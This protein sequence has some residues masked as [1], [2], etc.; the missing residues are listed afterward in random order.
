MVNYVL[1]TMHGERGVVMEENEDEEDDNNIPDWAAGQDFA[2]TLM[3][4][5]DKD[6]HVDDLGQVLKD[7]QRDCEDDNEKAKLCRMIEDHR[8]LLYP[9]CKQGHKKLG[10]TLEMLQWDAKYGVFDKAFEGMLKIVKDKLPENNELLSTTYETKQTVCRLGLEAQ[11]IHACPNDCILYRGTEHENLEACPV[12]KVLCYKIRRD[13]DP[14]APKGTPPKTTKVP[15]KVM[16]YFPIIPH[17]KRLFRNK[18]NAKLMTWHK[19]DRKQDHMLRHPADGYQWRMIDRK[20]KDFAG[21]A[22]NIRF[23]LSSD[24]FNPFGEFSIGHST[25]PVTLCMFNLPGRMCK[26]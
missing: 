18:E 7:A 15:A 13:D 23:G 20:Y 10:T 11:K 2:D 6:G 9:D 21:E 1:W 25:W 12:C 4:D 26:K 5:A 19:S 16:W 14:G 8:K 3:E 17:L 22:R 24:G